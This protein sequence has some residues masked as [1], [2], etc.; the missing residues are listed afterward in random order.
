M[1]RSTAKLLVL[2]LAILVIFFSVNIVWAEGEA[3]EVIAQINAALANTFDG[4][5]L[6]SN[7]KIVY[8]TACDE[9]M[10][11][12]EMSIYRPC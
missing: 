11:T 9:S 1:F 5:T 2:P 10:Q 12:L 7:W 4:K 6:K 3:D 8:K